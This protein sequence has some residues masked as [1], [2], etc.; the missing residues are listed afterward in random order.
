M[1]VLVQHHP[2]YVSLVWG[3]MK[4]LFGAVVEHE[5]VGRTLVTALNDIADALPRAELAVRLYPTES[6]QQAVAR[7]YAHIVRFLIR[8]MEWYNES[9]LTH[10]LHSITRPASLHYDDLIMEIKRKTQTMTN[11]SISKSQLE[12]R[13]MHK[14][15][16]EIRDLTVRGSR[17]EQEDVLNKLSSLTDIIVQ[18]RESLALDQSV[19]ASA[20][21]EFRSKLTDIQLTQALS[22]VSSQC[23]I[24]HT[25]VLRTTMALRDRRRLSIKTHGTGLWTSPKLRDWDASSA[26]SAMLLKATYRQRLEVRDFC[27]SVIEQLVNHHVVS[28]WVLRDKREYSLLEVFKSLIL[29]A[30]SLDRALHTDMQF[31]SQL[32]KFL[33]ARLD[34]DYLNILGDLLQHFNLVYIIADTGAMS[35]DDAVRCRVCL[36]QLSQRLAEREAQ[37]VVKVIVSS[38]GPA[39]GTTQERA[40]DVVLELGKGSAQMRKRQRRQR[41]RRSANIP[42][43]PNHVGKGEG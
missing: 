13:V 4:M 10:A 33:D 19:N 8:A 36:H 22:F 5:N 23:N 43:T 14:K 16:R 42:W 2:E 6:M 18:L 32:R 25:S 1:D 26:S 9:K 24:D 31:S 40:E 11:Y 27:A 3:A 29:Q 15:I 39:Q 41:G 20:R 37:T 28:L 34:D 38:Y 12:Q 7:L 21:L 35:V 30:L 17:C